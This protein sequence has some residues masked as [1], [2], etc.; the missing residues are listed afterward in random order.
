MADKTPPAAQSWP[1]PWME[2]FL[3]A[4][5]NS[6]NVRVACQAARVSRA[7][8]YKARK[9]SA[10]FAAAWEDS[11][12]DAVDTLEAVA[13]TRARTTS[14]YLLWRLLA[15]NRREKYGDVIK[16]TIDLEAEARRIAE[17]EGLS[18]EQASKI[19]SL[20]EHL[21]KGKTG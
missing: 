21:Q 17:R 12:E 13:W 20:A 11:L 4:L 9:Q 16:V 14:D 7:L 2:A 19:V 18:P 3:A 1:L 15:A 6:A 10:R 5:R 8:P